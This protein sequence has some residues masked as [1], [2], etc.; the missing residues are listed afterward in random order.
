MVVPIRDSGNKFFSNSATT[1]FTTRMSIAQFGNMDVDNVHR[2]GPDNF[3]D[4]RGLTKCPANDSSLVI[5]SVTNGSVDY[6]EYMKRNNNFVDKVIKPIDSSQL[7][8]IMNNNQKIQISRMAKLLTNIRPQ[9][10]NNEELF[11]SNHKNNNIFNIQLNYNINQ[12]RDRNFQA[13]SLHGSLEHLMSDMKNIKESLSRMQKYILDK[14]I[15]NGEANN[16]KDFKGVSKVAWR[17][18]LSLY[19]AY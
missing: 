7:L 18:I 15:K 8:C 2:G 4:V 11:C 1:M 10:V 5:M 16:V 12:A 3:D 19:K 17:F 14:T 13:I 9:H 6:A